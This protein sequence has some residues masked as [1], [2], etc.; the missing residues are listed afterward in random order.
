[1]TAA[2]RQRGIIAAIKNAFQVHLGT[3]GSRLVQSCLFFDA[4]SLAKC[5]RALDN[6]CMSLTL[7]L[8]F[9]VFCVF[10][11]FVF[12]SLLLWRRQNPLGGTGRSQH[13]APAAAAAAS[14]H[15]SCCSSSCCFHSLPKPVFL[16]ELRPLLPL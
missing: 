11:F 2:K 5:A 13:I 3:P 14:S 10:V 1:M 9:H 8:N 16:R 6:D 7:H 15:R 4:L 12:L